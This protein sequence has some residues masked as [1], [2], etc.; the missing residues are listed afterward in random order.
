V[1]RYVEKTQQNP[2]GLVVSAVQQ[3]ELTSEKQETLKPK[4]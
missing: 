2:Y 3:N 4:Q 1:L